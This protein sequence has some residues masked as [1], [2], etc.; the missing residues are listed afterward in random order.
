MK[1]I[2]VV[3]D[4]IAIIEIWQEIIQMIGHTSFTAQNGDNAVALLKQNRIDLIITDLNM[5][6]SD[7]MVVLDYVASLESA[8]KVIVSSG[9]LD[10]EALTDKYTI[11]KIIPKPFDLVTEIK[12]LES[13]LA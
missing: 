8:P 2:L 10:N 1:N 7:G 3:D 4:E 9:F 13:L 12:Y 6:H 11:E 5:P